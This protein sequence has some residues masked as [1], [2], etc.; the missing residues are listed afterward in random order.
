MAGPVLALKQQPHSS[1]NKQRPE[2]PPL[3]LC[4]PAAQAELDRFCNAMIAIREEITDIENGNA[5][6]CAQSAAALFSGTPAQLSATCYEVHRPCPTLLSAA[7][8][9]AETDRCS[10]H[11]LL[12]LSQRHT[13]TSR[14]QS[15]LIAV[16]G[17]Q[18]AEERAPHGRGGDGR[19][20]GAPLLARVGRLPG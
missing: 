20:V 6:K 9:L 7:H 12:P 17:G 8:L 1:S 14:K 16:Q 3:T 10:M 2:P 11:V 5:H 18:P 19:A 4:A 15:E 13:R